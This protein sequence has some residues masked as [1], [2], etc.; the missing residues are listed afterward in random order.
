MFP[1]LAETKRTPRARGLHTRDPKVYAHLPYLIEID[2]ET[3]R[4]R[5]N[6]LMVSFEI[7]GI[8]G[9]TSGQS[10]ILALRAGLAHLRH[11]R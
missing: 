7:I 1:E 4:T 6:A 11:A 5:E 8:D 9:V 2:D 3:V 10:T